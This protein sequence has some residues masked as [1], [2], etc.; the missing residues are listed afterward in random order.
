MSELP[1]SPKSWRG[2]LLP[3][4]LRLARA[5]LF[6]ERLWPAAWPALCVLGVFAVLV[7]FDLLP[8]LPGPIHA[9]VLAAFGLAFIGAVFWGWRRIYGPESLPDRIAA[10]RRIERS[11]GLPH[12]PLAALADRPSAL[13][14]QVHGGGGVP[15]L[16]IDGETRDF[17][18]VDKQNFRAEATLSSGK[19]LAINQGRTTLGRWPIEIVPDNPPTA[20]FA[21]PPKGTP[22]AALR[23]DSKAGDD[24]GVE[25]L[26]AVIQ[27]QSGKS[28]EKIEL[29]LPLPGL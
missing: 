8:L 10:R 26:K 23:L 14:A 17:E 3:A 5:A 7:L 1:A 24:Y 11:R 2:R 16:A 21:Q 4:R 15:R 6:W 25:T 28:D 9:A 29:E 27:L 19:S 22:R 20:A 18:A 12:R 13:L